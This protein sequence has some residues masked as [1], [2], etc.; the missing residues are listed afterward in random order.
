MDLWNL[1]NPK[2]VLH[3]LVKR[4]PENKISSLSNDMSKSKVHFKDYSITKNE[5]Q[6]VSSLL[7]SYSQRTLKM[8][9]LTKTCEW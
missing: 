6:T 3:S 5:Q 8:F 7:Y 1:L 9:Q 2:K 4:A